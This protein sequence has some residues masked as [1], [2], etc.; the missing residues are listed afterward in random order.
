MTAI[1]DFFGGNTGDP[2]GGLP[3][4]RTGI[5]ETYPRVLANGATAS[6]TGVWVA[7]ATYLP[8]GLRIVGLTFFSSGTALSAG[9]HQWFGLWNSSLALLA[10]SADDTSTAW[11]THTAK[12]L[13]L[14]TPFTTA[15]SGRYYVGYEITAT[16]VPTIV[17]IGSTGG[18]VRSLTPAHMILDN[19]TADTALAATLVNAA[20][21]VGGSQVPYAVLD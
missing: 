4:S 2:P 21:S 1:L 12:R 3:S 11:G 19:A 18:A 15:Y 14:T 17:G 20:A 7:G 16:T 10:G 8:A 6:G 13:T 5:A 9:T